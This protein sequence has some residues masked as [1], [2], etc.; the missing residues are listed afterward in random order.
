MKTTILKTTTQTVHTAI[1]RFT[2]L[3]DYLVLYLGLVWL[4][5]L[6]LSWTLVAVILYPLLPMRRAHALGRWVIMVL[7]RLY[8]SSLTASYRC[9]FDLTALD[10]L[11]GEAPLIIAPNHPSLLDAVMVISRLPNVACVMKS[12]LMNNIFLG[13]GSRLARYIRSEPL[14]D[15]VHLAV[16]DFQNGSHL[17][18]FPEGTRTTQN[19]VNPLGGSIGLIAYKAQVPVQT[20]LIETDTR[21]LSKGW[22]LFR[23]CVMPITFRVRLGR[24]FDPP[25]DT[26]QFMVE[27]QDYFDNELVVGSAFHPT[28]AFSMSK[29]DSSH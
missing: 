8:L 26:K 19:P 25:I 14:R 16:E 13:A 4:G 17:L 6:C 24:R 23:K 21:Y 29:V 5:M 20:V 9:H 12:S 15:M 10:A 27:L 28:G 1:H 22:P 11:R 3:Y 18:L 2:G 7:F